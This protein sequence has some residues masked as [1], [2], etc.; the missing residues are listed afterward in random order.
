[1]FV[2]GTVATTG[3]NLNVRQSPSLTATI[4]GTIPNGTSISGFLENGWIRGT[5]NGFTGYV[6]AQFVTY[7]PVENTE[8]EIVLAFDEAHSVNE[9][10]VD[11]VTWVRP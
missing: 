4:V 11:G 9:V 8:T 5:F 1:M 6:S 7:V 2:T 3:A 10:R